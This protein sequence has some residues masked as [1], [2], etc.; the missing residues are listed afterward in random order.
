MK[1]TPFVLL[2]LALVASPL[3]MAQ[4][5][6]PADQVKAAAKKLAEAP[7]YSWTTTTTVPE[8]SRWR[9]GPT[10]GKTNKDGYSWLSTTMGDRTSESI[11]KGTKSVTK[12][13]SGWQTAEER[14]AARD[15]AGGGGG[16]GGGQGR[17][18]RGGFGG[19]NLE[20][21]KTPAQQAEELAGQVKE[22]K[23]DGDVLSGDLTDEAV[24]GLLTM[25]GRRRDGSEGPSPTDAKGS[26]KFWLKD[27]VVAKMETHVSGKLSFNGN[28]MTIDRTSTTEVKDIGSTT[29]EIPEDAKSKL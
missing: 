12:G 7:N 27:G 23:K 25:G 2:T 24:K 10:S 1:R 13:D 11:I 18:G 17:G 26:V 20:N 28:E 5:A 14:R 8:G 15:A 9:P 16:Q 6:S 3:A 21:F 4:D 29:L 19:R 22:L